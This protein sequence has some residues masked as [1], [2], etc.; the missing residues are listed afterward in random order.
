MILSNLKF[1]S[2]TAARLRRSLAAL[3]LTL[4]TATITTSNVPAQQPSIQGPE[5]SALQQAHTDL[6]PSHLGQEHVAD[7]EDS[8]ANIEFDSGWWTPFVSQPVIS[9]LPPLPITLDDVLL[10]TLEYSSQVQVFSDLPLIRE[11]AVIEASAAFDWIQYLDSRW[12]DVSEPIG[13]SLTAGAG[14][15]RFSD[16]NLTGRAG[17]R[18]RTLSGGSFDI[19]QQLGFQDNNSQFFVPD[20]QG[21]AR[22]VIGFTQPLMRGR[23]V[24]YNQSLICLAKIDQRVAEDEFRRQLESHLLEVARSYWALYLER[25]ALYQKT[26]S[27]LRGKAIYDRLAARSELDANASQLISARAAIATRHSDLVRAQAAVRNAQ[28][29]LQSLVNNP[30]YGRM[31]LLPTDSPTFVSSSTDVSESVSIALQNRPEVLQ[32]IKQIKAAGIRLN[33][34]K[35][36]LLPLLNLVTQTHVSGLAAQ[37]D[38]VVAFRRQFDTG[39]PSY[40]I[41]LQYEFPVGNRAAKARLRRRKIELRQI[42]NQYSTTIETIRHEVS[43]GVRE[44]QTSM[45]ELGTKQAAMLARANQLDSMTARWEQLP[46][47]QSNKSLALEN[48]LLVQNQLAGSELE[49]LT[50]QLTYNLSLVN[51]KRV[52]GVLLQSDQVNISKFCECDL[53]RNVLSKQPSAE[54]AFHDAIPPQTHHETQAADPVN[55]LNASDSFEM[56]PDEEPRADAYQL[57]LTPTIQM[58]PSIEVQ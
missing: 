49:Y 28:S 20:P 34:S 39:A 14:V 52:T 2:R 27:Y 5:L 6:A 4:T 44:L 56:G 11:T 31:E 25:A 18:R 22:L 32:A 48:L 41:G 13:N 54:I 19:S 46:D 3:L 57:E 50:A 24:R 9:E 35:N 58:A 23:G 15:N 29:R 42:S 17:L 21:T 40:G 36:E 7:G 16:H 10:A 43:V 33:M 37:G 26:N 53:P 45:N 51:L 12:D 55:S 38:A 47:D 1:K 8:S 30:Q